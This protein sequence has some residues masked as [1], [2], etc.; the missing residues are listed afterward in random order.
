[1]FPF[2]AGQ[3]MNGGLL[4]IIYVLFLVSSIIYF[5]KVIYKNYQNG[6][7]FQYG[8]NK[9]VYFATILCMVIGQF[10]IPSIEERILI[11]LVFLSF[12]LLLYTILG[13]HNQANHSGD[14]LL[15][16]QKEIRKE[17]LCICIGI[18]LLLITLAVVH[19]TD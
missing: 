6:L 9:I 10:L 13:R 18:G 8:Q 15:F 3:I 1:M 19:F 7:S 12:I 4:M 14:M 5:A 2:C 17:K 11:F 16:F